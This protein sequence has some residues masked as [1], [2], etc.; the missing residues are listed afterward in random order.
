MNTT[1]EKRAI[2][3]EMA[4][5]MVE[6]AA[7][8]AKELG[9]PQVIAIIDDTGYTKA[10]GRMDGAPLMCE[11]IAQSKAF[12]ALFGMPTSEFF[13]ALK[14]QPSLLAGLFHRPRIAA[15][16][17]G[18]PIKAGNAVVGAIGVSG[19]TEE[20]DIACAQAAL[21]LAK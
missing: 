7:A 21:E 3:F 4:H 10:L 8:K 19:G 9:V 2:T 14:N 20:Q 16:G 13:N 6:A 17:G 15:F 18:L 11:E 5:K 1:Y 12:T